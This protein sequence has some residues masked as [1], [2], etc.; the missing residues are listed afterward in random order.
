MRTDVFNLAFAYL[1]LSDDEKEG[2]SESASISNQRMMI[3]KY[4]EQHGIILVD[5]FVDD[6]WSGGNFD[7]PAFQRMLQQLKLGKA[8]MVITKAAMPEVPILID[9][10]CV[11][12]NDDALGEAALKV[13]ESMHV[14]VQC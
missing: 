2:K 4:C 3:Q 13:M 9:A 7:R 12:S 1:R 8:N 6:G 11:A 5:E 14:K 10:A